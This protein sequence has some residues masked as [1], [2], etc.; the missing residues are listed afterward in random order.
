MNMITAPKQTLIA[1][2]KKEDIVIRH[3]HNKVITIIMTLI[4]RLHKPSS[5]RVGVY[6]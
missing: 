6:K 4:Y 3:E 2:Q 1:Y 5:R